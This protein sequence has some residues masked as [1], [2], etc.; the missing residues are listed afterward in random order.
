MI[1]YTN[2][3]NLHLFEKNAFVFDSKANN[4]VTQ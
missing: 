3:L 1:I 2:G 4:V